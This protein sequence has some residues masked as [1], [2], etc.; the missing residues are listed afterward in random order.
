M[1]ATGH[2]LAMALMRKF[3]GLAMAEPWL[4]ETIAMASTGRGLAMALMRNFYG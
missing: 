2:G 3:Y 1:A 4:F